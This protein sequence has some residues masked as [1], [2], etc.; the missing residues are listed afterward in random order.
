MPLAQLAESFEG[1][2]CA[3]MLLYRS[4]VLGPL[5]QPPASTTAT[6]AT[7]AATAAGATEENRSHGQLT[8]PSSPAA[9]SPPEP[10][11]VWQKWVEQRN[12]DW[13]QERAA[14][15]D[16]KH[17][18]VVEVVCPAHVQPLTNE[19]CYHLVP[20]HAGLLPQD[21]EAPSEATAAPAVAAMSAENATLPSPTTNHE[22]T[23]AGASMVDSSDTV[24]TNH[25]ARAASEALAKA[26]VPLWL[27]QPFTVEFDTRESVEEVKAQIASKLGPWAAVLGVAMTSSSTVMPATAQLTVGKS[28]VQKTKPE[29]PRKKAWGNATAQTA[30]PEPLVLASP[31]PQTLLQSIKLNRLEAHG[32]RGFCILDDINRIATTPQ[33]PPAAGEGTTALQNAS[34]AVSAGEAFE[35]VSRIL[36]WD[37]VQ[38]QGVAPVVDKALPI[39]LQVTTLVLDNAEAIDFGSSSSATSSSASATE[40]HSM[41]A[42]DATSNKKKTERPGRIVVAKRTLNSSSMSGSKA[43]PAPV[44]SAIELKVPIHVKRKAN[45]LEELVITLAVQVRAARNYF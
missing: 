44:V 5:A 20:C 9:A 19:D 38:V 34:A 8:S 2:Q 14:Y 41:T 10:P 42:L 23:T 15:D 18:V 11:A 21:A 12:Q 1:R 29:V 3:Y 22:A 24:S 4:R 26:G 33:A 37:G 35:G 43:K 31:E 39:T 32:T 30:Q 45:T 40:V 16:S 17:T 13:A 25:A 6:T 27:Q 36:A 28:S 7:A